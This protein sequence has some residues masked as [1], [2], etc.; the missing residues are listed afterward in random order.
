MDPYLVIRMLCFSSL[1]HWLI[2]RTNSFRYVTESPRWLLTQ[3]RQTDAMKCLTL[4]AKR[5]RKVIPPHLYATVTVSYSDYLFWYLQLM[6]IPHRTAPR[7]FVC[8]SFWYGW[9][10]LFQKE[11][12]SVNVTHIFRW[13]AMRTV[14][15]VLYYLWWVF[16]F[17]VD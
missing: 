2:F 15:L 5:N 12:A 1:F 3:G 9:K 17:N 16:L 7:E 10:F 8:I 6:R 11:E 13:P 4:I 14:T